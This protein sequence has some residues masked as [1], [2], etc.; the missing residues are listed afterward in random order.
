MNGLPHIRPV[1]SDV[2]ANYSAA[3][4]RGM[5]DVEALSIKTNRMLI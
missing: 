1:Y 2:L 4:K 5:G 3:G